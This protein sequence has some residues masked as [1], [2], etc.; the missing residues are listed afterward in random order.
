[1]PNQMNEGKMTVFL[2]RLMIF[3]AVVGPFANLPQ[4]LKIWIKKKTNGVS[5]VSWILFSILSLVW[6]IYGI[7]KKDKYIIITFG[8]TLILQLLIVIGTVIY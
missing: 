7:V 8:I 5:M 1:M 2:E 3:V 4:L 6:L